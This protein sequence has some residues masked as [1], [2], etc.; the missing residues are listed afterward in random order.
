MTVD[1]SIP[2]AYTWIWLRPVFYKFQHFLWKEELEAN[3]PIVLMLIIT[4]IYGI[5]SSGQQTTAGFVQLAKYCQE[6]FPE[7]WAVALAFKRDN[8]SPCRLWWRQGHSWKYCLCL[9][10]CK[11]WDKKLHILRLIA[12]RGSLKWWYTPWSP[13]LQVGPSQGAAEVEWSPRQG[14]CLIWWA[15]RSRTP[16]ITKRTILS[17]VVSV[18][19]TLGLV[20]PVTAKLKLDLH[21]ITRLNVDWD[22][23]LLLA[24]LEFDMSTYQCIS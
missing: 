21:D 2:M 16:S 11:T 22:E 1:T 10:P 24:M 15:M 14:S 6:H 9:L 17:K 7:H 19:D 23:A 5:K 3:N 20:T 4:L 8:W 18:Y 13:G 12:F